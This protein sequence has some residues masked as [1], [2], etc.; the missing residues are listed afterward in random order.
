MK[1]Y[2]VVVVG[3]GH[4]GCATATHLRALGFD[5]TVALIGEEAGL[6]YERP[7]LS[8]R[9]LEAPVD[10]DVLAL[11][12]D[13]F[14]ADED[15]ELRRGCRVA[16]VDVDRRRIDLADGTR[17][18]W[19][20]L[21]LATGAAPSVPPLPGADI[22]EVHVLRSADDAERLAGAIGTKRRLVVV[23][24]GYVGL[25][26]AA[27][28]RT[29]GTEVTVLEAQSRVLTRTAGPVVASFLERYHRSRGVDIRTGVQVEALTTAGD[30]R[31]AA[32][33]MTDGARVECDAVLLA[34]GAAPRDTLA[35]RAGLACQDGIS[36][37]A[38]GATSA[39]DVYAV[40]DVTVRPVPR[41]GV[42]L[43]LESVQ[44]AHEQARCVAA[45]I[46][47]TPESP[48]ETPWF[49]SDQYD[50]KVQIAGLRSDSDATV[51]RGDPGRPGFAVF[52]VRG[53]RLRS[54]EA[55]NSPREFALGRK[56]IGEEARVSVRALADPETS[57]REAVLRP[58]APA[59]R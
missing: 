14:Y 26:V 30:G 32:V 51:V 9:W 49:W 29:L 20:H 31:A 18:G 59:P 50:L 58:N 6:P 40:G 12:P 56:F 34:V 39:R 52:H 11:R 27:T 33:R 7:P 17:L 1:V 54:V 13:A 46:C 42:R 2:D 28:A 55:V 57:L 43:R 41:Y 16:G 4:A 38:H 25:E 47:G 19:R 48:Q 23:G 45:A 36:V 53:D 44:S 8:K 35:R 21:V 3:A 15:I 24:G 22:P 5:G 37:D 10:R